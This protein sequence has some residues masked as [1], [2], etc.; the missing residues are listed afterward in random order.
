MHS[1]KY[2][3][4][5]PSN[6]TFI[7]FVSIHNKRYALECALNQLGSKCTL[8]YLFFRAC[9]QNVSVQ[10]TNNSAFSKENHVLGAR[11]IPLIIIIP[12]KSKPTNSPI[13]WVFLSHF[14][15]P[16][17]EFSLTMRS[18]LQIFHFW[19]NT[20]C[21]GFCACIKKNA[22]DSNSNRLI[23]KARWEEAAKL[24]EPTSSLSITVMKSQQIAC[25]QH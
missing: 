14:F 12:Y 9:L 22:Y 2:F 25:A 15:Q 18:S 8:S 19:K 3:Q 6:Q 20:S 1:L 5:D 13:V 7:C 21:S 11:F 10:Y 17:I 16:L 24:S 4:K 23:E